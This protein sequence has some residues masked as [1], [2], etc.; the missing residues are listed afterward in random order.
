MGPPCGSSFPFTVTFIERDGDGPTSL[1]RGEGH[2]VG[3][4]SVV[5]SEL[6]RRGGGGGWD[7]GR[8]NPTIND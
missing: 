7:E 2:T 3:V 8:M 6:R 4:S 1:R 5:G